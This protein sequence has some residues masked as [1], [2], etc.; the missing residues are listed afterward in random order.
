MDNIKEGKV[1]IYEGRKRWFI[2]TPARSYTILLCMIWAKDFTLEFIRAAFLR[3][4][5]I[6]NLIDIVL[7]V[8]FSVL[9]L[10]ALPLF[11]KKLR[12]PDLV[13]G[14]LI[15]VAMLLNLVIFPDNSFFTWQTVLKFFTQV[16]ALYYLGLSLDINEKIDLLYK[17]SVINVV[18]DFVY[19]MFINEK[20]TLI[21]SIYSGNMARA[22][23]LLPHVCLVMIM[24]FRK[25][26]LLSI[27]TAILGFILI[28]AYGSRGPLFIYALFIVL[29]FMFFME[30]KNNLRSYAVILSIF[31]IVTVFFDFFI[32]LL[33]NIAEFMGLSI[34]I[35]LKFTEGS[36]FDANGRDELAN[37]VVSYIYENPL[38]GG[39]FAGDRPIIGVYSHNLA[40]EMWASF[41]VIIGTAIVVWI[42]LIILRGLKHSDTVGRLFILVFICS[43]VIRLFFSGSYL[44]DMFL[45][46]LLGVCVAQRRKESQ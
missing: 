19:A 12:I 45:Y 11:I 26:N 34:R 20:M 16:F 36:L 31:T 43:S 10:G 42:L 44:E 6:S 14:T 28:F 30:H 35:L 37:A 9:T 22:Y 3:I 27:V 4:P 41:G 13:A 23:E 8:I 7:A 32:N 2:I 38:F 24:T 21:Q 33:N 5:V 17:I 46:F 15:L 1:N 25:K 40:L 29:C 18:L 39:G